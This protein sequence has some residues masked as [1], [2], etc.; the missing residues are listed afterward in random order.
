MAKIDDMM[1]AI[2]EEAVRN[3]PQESCGLILKN[4]KK[5]TTIACKNISGEPKSSF[6][7]CPVDYAKATELGEV[8]GV[9]HTHVEIPPRAS[10][11]DKVGCERSGLPWYIVSIRKKGEEFEFEGPNRIEPE[12]FEMPYL[13]RPYEENVFNCYTIVQDYYKREFDI[14]LGDYPFRLSD[15]TP[16]ATEKFKSCY[17]KEGFVRL[18]DEEP[19]NGDIFM[20]QISADS[21]NHVGVYVGEGA[22]IHHQTGRLSR[23]DIYGGFWKKHT[24]HHLR[25]KDMTK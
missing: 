14:S 11:A 6:T 16:A 21:P 23:K 8:V 15:G 24:T 12:S 9:W 4:N 22:F 10:D 19:K 13:E 3:Y 2:K 25:Y 1:T 20:M 7:I 5:F 17:E 18:H